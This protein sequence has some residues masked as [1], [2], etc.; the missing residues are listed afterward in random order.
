MPKPEA[1]AELKLFILLVVGELTE[2]RGLGVGGSLS[3]AWLQIICRALNL[4]PDFRLRA[5]PVACL[6]MASHL[7]TSLS[8]GLTLVL[9]SSMNWL[10]K[11][12]DRCLNF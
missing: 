6:T 7:P 8:Q 2:A 9:E 3:K 12:S 1:G 10:T 4:E 11:I 5:L